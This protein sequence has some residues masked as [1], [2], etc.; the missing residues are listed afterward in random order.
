MKPPI[1]LVSQPRV[2]PRKFQKPPAEHQPTCMARFVL[3]SMTRR[4]HV[5]NDQSFG[6]ETFRHAVSICR[7]QI[8][9]Q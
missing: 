8:V 1:I 5:D 9:A 6:Q 4:F 2:I 7:W 3:P